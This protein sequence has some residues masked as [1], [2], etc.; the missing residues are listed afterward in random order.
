MRFLI[1]FI[2]LNFSLYAVQKKGVTSPSSEINWEIL[3]TLELDPKTKLPNPK[4][5]LKKILGTVV[6]IKGFMMPLDFDAKAVSEFL[7]MPYVPSCMHV[8][9]PPPNQL[10]LV[11]MKKGEKAQSSFYP[12][13]ITGKI[14]FEPNKDLESG[15][16]MEGLKV[17]E[18]KSE[19]PASMNKDM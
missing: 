11:K 6:K 2:A 15:Y 17:N 10:I 7:L 18:I 5:E 1:C 16:K 9:P 12:V 14:S 4:P 3:R 8:P 13:E 19:A